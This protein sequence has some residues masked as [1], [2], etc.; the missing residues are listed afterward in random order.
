ML[1]PR[2]PLAAIAMAI[3][4]VPLTSYPQTTPRTMSIRLL[5][6]KTGRPIGNQTVI[7]ATFS[8]ERKYLETKAV[9]L[10]KDGTGS[11]NF[12]L[13]AERFEISG[14]EDSYLNECGSQPNP[15]I[16]EQVLRSGYVGAD[17]CG[18]GTTVA[19]AGEIVLWGYTAS[20]LRRLFPVCLSSLPLTREGNTTRMS[21][22]WVSPCSSLSTC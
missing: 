5:N 16:I 15:L 21:S 8:R 6:G 1:V 18:S 14:Y 9:H 2:L 4:F 22:Y 13:E 19:H 12:P 3:L 20:K 10:A 17:V 7:L 11:I